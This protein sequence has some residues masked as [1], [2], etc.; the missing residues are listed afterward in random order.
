MIILTSD[1]EEEPLAIIEGVP[2]PLVKWA[3]EGYTVV[4][5]QA[6]AL[7]TG[8]DHLIKSAIEALE[9][10]EK[11]EPKDKIGLVGQPQ[12]RLYSKRDPF[13]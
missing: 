13:S 11:C 9:A 3:E 2:S 1:Y 8:K 10:C 6:R 4:E 12:F 7:Q 5:I